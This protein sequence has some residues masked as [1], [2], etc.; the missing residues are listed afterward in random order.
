V[1]YSAIAN[2]FAQAGREPT[3]AAL[4]PIRLSDLAQPRFKANPFPFYARM[5]AEA[6]AFEVTG[7]FFR[8]AWLVTRYDD[9]VAMLK[10]DRLAKDISAKMVWLPRF[11]RPAT[12][13]ML[14]RDPPDHTRLR[15]LVSQAF[16]SRRIEQLRARIQEVCDRLLDPVPPGGTFDVVEGYALPLPVTVIADLLGI[17]EGGRRRFQ[18]LASHSLPIGAPSRV[19]DVVAALPYV[20]LLV[21]YFRE[22]FA[23]RRARPRDDLITALVAAEEAGDRL[24]DDELLGMGVLLLLAGYETTFNLIATGVLALLQHPDQKDRF[25]REPDLAGSAVEELLRYTSPV[26]ITPP[27]LTRE[28]IT[29]GTVTIPPGMIVAAVLASAN[30]DESRFPDPEAL[31][32][33]R[34]PNRHVAFGAGSHFCLGAALARMEAEIALTTLFRR[35][36]NLR[37]AG[38]P[39]SV[40]WRRTLP[41][42]G[43][44]AL[45]VAV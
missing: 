19:L 27:R 37:L 42:R 34:S 1:R 9:V 24:S 25:A 23:E 13:H 16:T 43:L 32:L 35:F 39:A 20:W 14:N 8:R 33:A 5:R 3:T 45:P 30:H 41:L 15:G 21:R 17:P 31:D 12:H 2:G 40:R 28:E 22:L 18:R 26:E 38:G 6:P 7:P 4:E 29:L 11:T 36:P 10:D 44:D